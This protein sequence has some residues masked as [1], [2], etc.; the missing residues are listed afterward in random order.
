MVTKVMKNAKANELTISANNAVVFCEKMNAKGEI[1]T[2]YV[3]LGKINKN[4]ILPVVKAAISSII[5]DETLISEIKNK[6]K[7]LETEEGTL[8]NEIFN[9]P[10]VKR[11]IASFKE[12]YCLGFSNSEG[13]IT[14]LL[15]V[16]NQNLKSLLCLNA[17]KVSEIWNANSETRRAQI[18]T[19][20]K[21]ALEAAVSVRENQF[22]SRRTLLEGASDT[23]KETDTKKE[24]KKQTLKAA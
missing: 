13:K 23:A 19:L 5:S 9:A 8:T 14:P 10:N 1:S 3:E 21:F 11:L 24:T 6:F 15:K 17:A 2:T 18:H 7:F 16:R 4:E 20:A 22:L 12:N